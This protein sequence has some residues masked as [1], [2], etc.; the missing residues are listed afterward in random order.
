MITSEIFQV[1]GSGFSAPE[2]AAMYL[3]R[4][5]GHFGIF[6]GKEN[7][8]DFIQSFMEKPFSKLTV[9]VWG[10]DPLSSQ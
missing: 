2:D 6:R 3:I 8:R 9:Q 10:R 1:G 4:C 5:E 7:V